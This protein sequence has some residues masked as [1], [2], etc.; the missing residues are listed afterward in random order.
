MIRNQE[1]STEV[2]NTHS[3]TAETSVSTGYAVGAIALG[4]S[5]NLFS[6][7]VSTLM[8]TYLPDSVQ[9][10]L[11]SL[12]EE[13]VSFVGSYIGAMYIV[14]WAV[15]GIFFGWLADRVGRIRT[16]SGALLVVGL[17]TSAASF[18]PNWL[19]LVAL[20]L[21]TGMGVGA[22]M[23]LCAV[24]A[25]EIWGK[26][27]KGR[28]IA[29]SILA[30]GFPIGIISSGLVT[31][32]VTDW[33]TAFL[34][35]IAPAL[36]GL[37]APILFSEPPQ[38]RRTP[39]D[40]DS[41]DNGES[42]WSWLLSPENKTNF[43]A[44]AVIFG[45]MSIGIWSTFSWLPTWAQDLARGSDSALQVGGT[46]IALLGM[47]GIVGSLLSGPLANLLGRRHTLMVAF[48][49]AGISAVFL[50]LTNVEFDSIIY[51]Q[52]AGLALFFGF[53]QGILMAYIP[54]LFPTSIRSTAT[55]ICFNLGRILT[56]LAVF[57]VGYLVPILGGYGN[58]LLVFSLTYVFGFAAVVMAPETR[59]KVL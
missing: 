5:G 49:G 29:M 9:D 19:V 39:S 55:G 40:E 20:R 14:G 28:A 38:W 16:L 54:E 46:L 58:A 11:G 12:S 31:W 37:V 51:V 25:A 1:R 52:T 4:F 6:G 44:G 13:D 57:F 41:S 59:N 8:A 33:R 15:G 32:L 23:V 10:L 48:A 50:F 43:V 36:L 47:G 45:A 30:I 53:S 42:E 34:I 7:L 18:S 2:E 27:V 24:F 21:V 17:A 26:R 22:T 35:G 56:A 3:S